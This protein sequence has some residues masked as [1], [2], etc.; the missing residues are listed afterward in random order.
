MLIYA[1]THLPNFRIQNLKDNTEF[2]VI[3][4]PHYWCEY[5]IINKRPIMGI[6]TFQHICS[7]SLILQITILDNLLTYFPIITSIVGGVF[8]LGQYIMAAKKNKEL[9]EK[10]SEKAEKILESSLKINNL[11][12]EHRIEI[13]KLMKDLKDSETA[14]S[15]WKEKY[16]EL[17]RDK[18]KDNDSP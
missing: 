11:E 8:I 15:M 2:F 7:L 13:Q 4:L 14:S 18:G 9:A 17:L 5:T 16:F 12:R 1:I 10:E 3:Y 6:L